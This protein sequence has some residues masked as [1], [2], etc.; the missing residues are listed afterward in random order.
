MT[1]SLDNPALLTDRAF[2][3]GEWVS[4]KS[5]AA[6]P[7]DNPATGAVIG[8][9][10]DCGEEDTRAAILAAERAYPAWRARTANDRAALLERWHAL[11]LENIADLARIM[12]AEQ[13]KPLAEAE[14]EIRYAA[15]FIKWFAEEARRV[16]GAIIPAP[17]TN[18]RI[19][20]MK[21][22]VGRV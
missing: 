21:E 1:L 3:G 19:L 2:I 22:R 4:A 20:V 18:R 12:T 17:E 14:G 8:T 5:G 15:T 13:G 16:D 9:V 6:V 10:P 11:V 7:V